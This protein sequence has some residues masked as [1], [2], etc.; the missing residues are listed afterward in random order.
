MGAAAAGAAEELAVELAAAHRARQD[1]LCA[2]GLVGAGTAFFRVA[3]A[4]CTQQRAGTCETMNH[5]QPQKTGL[6]RHWS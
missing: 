5:A 1:W 6:Q 3:M 4:V 2:R